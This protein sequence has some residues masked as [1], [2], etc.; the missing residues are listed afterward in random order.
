M[1]FRWRVISLSFN[2]HDTKFIL[3]R[4]QQ[5][6]SIWLQIMVSRTLSNIVERKKNVNRI[7]CHCMCVRKCVRV[8]VFS[9]KFVRT[10]IP[11]AT[12]RFAHGMRIFNKK[13]EHPRISIK[14]SFHSICIENKRIIDMYRSDLQEFYWMLV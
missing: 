9:T 7:G 3:F 13:K 4:F 14:S 6:F 5:K 1:V 10:Q 12:F 11:H 2:C 8:C